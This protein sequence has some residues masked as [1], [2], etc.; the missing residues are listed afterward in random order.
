M[1]GLHLSGQQVADLAVRLF[2]PA[3][4]RLSS[5]RELR[6]G[7]HGS[8][9]VVPER[10]V[11]CDHE[12]GDSGGLLDMVVHAGAASTVAEAARW[13]DGGIAS[14][15]RESEVEQA[16]RSAQRDRERVA[17]EVAAISLWQARAPLFGTAA[18]TYLR[19]ARG[20]EAP[21][22][23]AELGF[24]ASAPLYPYQPHLAHRPALIAAVRD[25]RGEVRGCHLTYLRPDGLGKA[26]LPAARKM[27]GTIGGGHVRLIPGRRLVVAEGLES[28]LSGW[29]V[30]SRSQGGGDLGASAALSAGGV[31]R[32]EWPTGT[33]SLVIAPDRDQSGAGERAARALARRASAVGLSVSFLVPPDGC[34]DWNDV[35]RK[36]GIV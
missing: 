17:R 8:L 27:V 25:T 4:D 22:E 10:G 28:T 35:S 11:F 6:F 7:N 32:F 2:G 9:S 5:P 30:A 33:D 23:A 20:V 24:L 12:S 15:S 18:E 34:C 14:T 29:E 26:T 19:Q 21:L 31:E 3:N 1:S 16:E 13:L 36:G